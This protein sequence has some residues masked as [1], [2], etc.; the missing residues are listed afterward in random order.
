VE[1]QFE[2]E[3][4]VLEVELAVLS[5][6]LLLELQLV[7]SVS[8]PKHRLRNPHS[9]IFENQDLYSSPTDS[10]GLVMVSHHVS[11][12]LPPVLHYQPQ[13]QSTA[14]H[15]PPQAQSSKSSVSPCVAYYFVT[16][17]RDPKKT[18]FPVVAQVEQL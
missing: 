17:R 8:P 11:P 5:L 3:L 1:D 16:L 18:D 4:M 7:S 10:P 12:S 6:L 13:E 15:Q 14:T 2:R 9:T